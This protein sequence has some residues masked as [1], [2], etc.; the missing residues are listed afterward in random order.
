MKRILIAALLAA[1][2][3]SSAQAQNKKELVQKLLQLEQPGVEQIARSLVERSV[4]PMAQEAGQ[5]V[6]NQIAPEKREEVSNAIQADIKKYVDE[7]T[8]LVRA[9][10]IKLAP[11]TIGAALEDKLSEDELK[12]IIAW[13]ESPVSKKYQQLGAD[14]RND[15][16]QK[17]I[18]DA[19]PQ[20]DPKLQALDGRIRADLG[21]PAAGAAAANPGA[22]ATKPAAAPAKSSKPSNPAP[23]QPK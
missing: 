21:L 18:A 6:Q 7:S 22:S 11:A 17:V 5:A 9:S 12:Q 4:A 14:V 3:L 15:F 10:A 13:Y 1:A 2:A 23:R 16:V 19:R 8:V 20:V